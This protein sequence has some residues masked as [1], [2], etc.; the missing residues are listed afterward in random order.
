MDLVITSASVE[1]T[2]TRYSHSTFPPFS[3][4]PKGEKTHLE[5]DY[6]RMQNLA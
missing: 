3:A 6:A 4:P 1:L 5:P 2:Q